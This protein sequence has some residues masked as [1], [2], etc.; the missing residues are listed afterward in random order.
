VPIFMS[1]DSD[2]TIR[3]LARRVV[4]IRTPL[5]WPIG[6]LLLMLPVS[7][8]A[9]FDVR[10]SLS[11]VIGLLLGMAIFYVTVA[12]VYDAKHLVHALTLY[13]CIGTGVAALGLV[14]TRWLY[15]NPLLSDIVRR[16]PQWIRGLPGATAGFHPNEVAGVL[17]WF[18]PLL[19][20]LLV[21]FWR[22][23]RLKSW[24]GAALAFSTLLTTLTLILTQS[25]GGWLGL[26]IGLAVMGACVDR[27]VRIGLVL[28]SI[29]ALAI[30][31]M[32]GPARVGALLFGEATSEALGTLNW[33]LRIQVWRAALWGI[34]D[35]PFTGM[36]LGTFRRVARVLYPLDIRPGYDIAHAHNGFLQ[37][38]I[39]LGIPGLIAY[40]SIW[41]SAA[42][43][44][45][46]SVRCAEGWPLALSRLRLDTKTINDDN[47]TRGGR[48]AGLRALAIGFGGCLSSYFVF[49]L[50]D[51]IALGAKPT[52][53]WWMM[54][55]LIVGTSRL[56]RGCGKEESS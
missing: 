43:L 31:G 47:R 18:V 27:R 32:Q 54:L 3:A 13:L 15:K 56:L 36:G 16:L 29:A 10:L 34:G 5:D 19:I 44:V 20:A 6:L 11:K 51:T 14:G 7:L 25:R 26:S 40:T 21:W 46:S 33:G 39:D 52:P 42:W 2:L 8:W 45:T 30:L 41:L 49:S 48:S 53:A 55:G 4:A 35:F 50:L 17:L 9:T 12:Y 24:E 28:L 22:Q 23:G 38:G 37:A 1:P